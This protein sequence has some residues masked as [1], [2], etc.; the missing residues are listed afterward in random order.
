MDVSL[1]PLLALYERARA[2]ESPLVLATVVA[3]LGSTYRK[4][5]AQMLIT[6]DGQY[7][8]LLSGG[9]LEN[10]LVEHAKPVFETGSP[11]LVKYDNSG[12]D[13]L[14]WGLGAGCDGGMDVWLVRLDPAASWT[15]FSVLASCFDRREAVTYGLVLASSIPELPAGASVW[16]AGGV[17]KPAGLASPVEEWID[18]QL[19]TSGSAADTRIVQLDEPCVQLFVSRVEP[20]RELLLVGGGPDALPVVEFAAA[21]GWRVTVADHRPAYAAAA[22]FPKARRMLLAAPKELSRHVELASFDAAVIMSHH[23]ATD[24]AALSTLVES[25][26]PYVGLLGPALRRKQLFADLGPTAA[27]TYGARLHAPVGLDLGGRDPA[28]IALAI[29]AEIQAFFHG[30]GRAITPRQAPV[31]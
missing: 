6:A 28:S 19:Q 23:F 4:A 17:T 31:A 14:L 27:A 10:D 21:L 8:G 20:P 1:H 2:E 24:L 26:I 18:R 15:P 7:A 25:H 29:V 5:G 9:C 22:K 30:K 3:T 16:S 12:E 13:D 11:K